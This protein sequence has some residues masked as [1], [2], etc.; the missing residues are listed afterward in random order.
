[1]HLHLG[2]FLQ[3]GKYR[4]EKFLGQGGFGITYLATQVN[5][6]RSVA[7]KEFFFR[8][9]CGRDADTSHVT[10][11]TEANKELVGRFM[12]KFIK[13]AQ[14]IA[15]FEHPNIVKIIDTFTENNT[16][17]YVMEYIDGC[18][19]GE[20]VKQRG[21]LP[22]DEAIGYI[23]QVGEALKYIHRRDVNHLDIKPGNILLRNEDQVVKVIDFG[24]AK[25]YD[26]ATKEGTTTTPVGISHGYSPAEQYKK[27]GVQTFSPQSDVYALAATLFKLLTGQTPPEAMEVLDNGLPVEELQKVGV[28]DHVIAAIEHA[29][30]S[31]RLRTQTVQE[32]LDELKEPVAKVKK[33]EVTEVV[34]VEEEKTVV[35]AEIAELAPKP[36]PKPQPKPAPKPE[37]KPAPAP[38]PEPKLE[39]KPKPAPVPKPEPQPEPKPVSAPKPEPE[40]KPAPTPIPEPQP[41]PVYPPILQPAQQPKNKSKKVPAVL[42]I[43]FAVVVIGFIVLC[44]K[45]CK[46]KSVVESYNEYVAPDSTEV[47][48]NYAENQEIVTERGTGIY[49]GPVD[50]DGKPHGEGKMWYSDMTYEG[51]FNHGVAEGVFVKITFSNGTVYQGS[52]KEGNPDKGTMTYPDGSYVEG[53][54]DKYCNPLPGSVMYN[55]N[56]KKIG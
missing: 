29:M 39:P 13:E 4:I 14:T 36:Q 22:Q 3:D 2:S 15:R 28:S 40:P 20:L 26:Q 47:Q 6:E 34:P 56:G 33:E 35:V 23:S 51:T 18:S 31:R 12:K 48:E 27:N 7:I 16:A 24:V 1:M 53:S 17:Y 5:L 37:P 30:Q 44:L 49:T 32:F 25:Q 55:K 21:F 8:D 46:E 42:W 43:I 11:G 38:K 41:E 50:E 9:Y 19:L 10:L 52:V 54:F 45:V